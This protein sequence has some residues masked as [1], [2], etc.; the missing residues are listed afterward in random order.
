MPA[1]RGQRLSFQREIETAIYNSL[2]H[3]IPRLLRLHPLHCP[4]A[5]V[6][7]T[8]SVEV[9]QVGL[10]ATRRLTQ[11]RMSALPGGHLFPFEKPA[12][13]AAEV[14]RWIEVFEGLPQGR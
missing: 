4:L 8:E 3:H 14:L 5:F 12:E 1:A 2:P 6:R 10:T 13:T 7:G 9:R 11:G